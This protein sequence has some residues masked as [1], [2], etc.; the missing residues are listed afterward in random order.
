MQMVKM[1]IRAPKTIE[2]SQLVAV[3]GGVM[4]SNPRWLWDGLIAGK[5]A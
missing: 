5:R 1:R 4:L 3:I 2:R